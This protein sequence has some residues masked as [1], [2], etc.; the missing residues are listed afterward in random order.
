MA[1][2][3][4]LNDRQMLKSL[5]KNTEIVLNAKIAFKWKTYSSSCN[6]FAL[7][8]IITRFGCAGYLYNKFR[9]FLCIHWKNY[10]EMSIVQTIF[11]NFVGFLML[12]FR[13][14]VV[15]RTRIIRLHWDRFREST[16]VH[17]K[18][19][20]N[21]VCT[22]NS[23]ERERVGNKNDT[24]KGKQSNANESKWTYL[25]KF[26]TRFALN[27]L[28]IRNKER[29]EI[30]VAK[31][32]ITITKKNSDGN[33]NES[34]WK[35]NK[36]NENQSNW[37][38][39]LLKSK[40]TTTNKNRKKHNFFEM[41]Q[42]SFSLPLRWCVCVSKSATTSARLDVQF[43]NC[44]G[45]R[46]HFQTF[47]VCLSSLTVSFCHC[48]CYNPVCAPL[49]NYYLFCSILSIHSLSLLS[50]CWH[51]FFFAA[52]VPFFSVLNRVYGIYVSERVSICVS[53]LRFSSLHTEK[54]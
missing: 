3:K 32:G 49:Q 30:T 35:M 43:I 34:N 15:L 50:F 17:E 40:Q 53:F 29:S 26:K 13:V 8:F 37:F 27:L 36:R 7:F 9:Q 14:M 16:L 48:H 21:N 52:S 28:P 18:C 24:Q 1:K 12:L 6:G 19:G 54:V 46:F 20:W 45:H 38:V 4:L 33:P 42:L 22:N 11:F 41:F 39:F 23:R 44:W 31:H 10:I 2:Q 47:P 5:K 51:C 25:L